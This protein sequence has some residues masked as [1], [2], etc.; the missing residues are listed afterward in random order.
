MK[1]LEG[2]HSGLVLNGGFGREQMPTTWCICLSAYKS[3]I[4]RSQAF[5]P[6]TY[7]SDCNVVMKHY[8]FIS[9]PDLKLVI[10]LSFNITTQITL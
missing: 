8:L 1:A 4:N 7:K 2:A 3:Q 6:Q 5:L 10:M 9:F